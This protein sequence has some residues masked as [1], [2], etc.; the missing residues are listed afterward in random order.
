MEL[1]WLCTTDSF[2]GCKF[3]IV[4]GKRYCI[5]FSV[6]FIS[7]TE[8]VVFMQINYYYFVWV[9][10]IFAIFTDFCIVRLLRLVVDIALLRSDWSTDWLIDFSDWFIIDRFITSLSDW[11]MCVYV[12]ALLGFATTIIPRWFTYY[13]SCGLFAVFGIKMLR[14]GNDNLSSFCRLI[15]LA[16]WRWTLICNDGIQL[17]ITDLHCNCNWNL[18]DVQPTMSNRG[19]KIILHILYHINMWFLI[20]WLQ[21]EFVAVVWVVD[22]LSSKWEREKSISF[23][24]ICLVIFETRFFRQSVALTVTVRLKQWIT[25][26]AP[27]LKQTDLVKENAK[28][29]NLQPKSIIRVCLWM[30]NCS[31][32]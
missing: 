12:P 18:R 5:F 20:L 25:C 9:W 8:L 21:N 24:S 10:S 30:H 19:Q 32:Q 28:K 27:T 6:I 14:E 3:G 31:T 16:L 11:V 13:V 15:V 1:S 23:Q 29:T 17:T 22:E 26:T 7:F 4:Y 2:A